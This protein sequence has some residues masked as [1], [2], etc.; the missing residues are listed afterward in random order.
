MDGTCLYQVHAY[1]TRHWNKN[2]WSLDKSLKPKLIFNLTFFLKPCSQ[3]VPFS[4]SLS[5]SL[6]L[7]PSPPPVRFL[8][9]CSFPISPSVL[10][11]FY[12]ESR[13]MWSLIVLSFTVIKLTQVPNLLVTF[14]QQKVPYYYHSVNVITLSWSQSDHIKRLTLYL[15]FF[16][17]RWTLTTSFLAG[18]HQRSK[19]WENELSG[20]KS[21]SG[22][23]S[24]S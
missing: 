19:I 6:S 20:R 9:T 21:W 7:S 14:Y 12:S 1:F 23:R 10:L 8:S 13:L 11:S 3:H 24:S 22:C 18:W 15:I 2:G 16:R 5:L 17:H 4:L